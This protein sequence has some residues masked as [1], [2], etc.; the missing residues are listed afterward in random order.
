MFADSVPNPI[1]VATSTDIGPARTT[2][3]ARFRAINSPITHPPRPLPT[4]WS[5]NFIRNWRR[6]TNRRVTNEKRK[7]AT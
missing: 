3:Q 4:S 6:K 2:I 1:S 5:M 7:G